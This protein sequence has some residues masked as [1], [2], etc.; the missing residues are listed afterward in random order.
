MMEYL[1]Y[2]GLGLAAV[3]PVANPLTSVTLMLSLSGGLTT[4]ERNQ[5]IDKATLY[6]MAIMV[7]CFYSGQAI[8]SGFGISIPGL[9][10]A[11][12]FVVIYIGFTMLFPGASLT[13]AIAQATLKDECLEGVEIARGISRYKKQRD[14]A[15]VPLALPGTAGPG[16]IAMIISAASTIQSRGGPTPI[17]HL[18]F[19]TVA[20]LVAG[21]FWA[22]LRSA[23][24][25][26]D[27]LGESG[28][29]AISRIM[30]FL[31]ICMGV[32]FGIDGIVALCSQYGALGFVGECTPR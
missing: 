2:V 1:Q 6:V 27:V 10:I 12:G 7:V 31:L 28:I 11:G 21:T 15:F 18:S 29:D 8:M 9:R 30:G 20:V 4:T 17:H 5:Q 26:V 23:N 3:L 25:V 19:L 32:Q 24:R 14:I 16:T 22:C 13:E